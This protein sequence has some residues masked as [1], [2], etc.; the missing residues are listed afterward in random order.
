MGAVATLFAATASHRAK[1]AHDVAT[2]VQATIGVDRDSPTIQQ[3]LT[4]FTAYEDYQHTRNHDVL[5]RLTLVT[6][7]LPTLI[8]A[9]ESQTDLLR[10]ILDRLP[11]G[12]TDEQVP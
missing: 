6:A 4:R 2:S 11:E 9:T 7:G 1:K 3:L 5:D 12:E 10:R 8:R